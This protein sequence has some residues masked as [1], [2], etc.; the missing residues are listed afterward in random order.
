MSLLDEYF[1]D[2]PYCG[3]NISILIDTSVDYQDYYE[4]CSVCCAP[5]FFLISCNGES[6]DVVIKSDNE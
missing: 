2:C 6:V 4:D 5:I 3:E 1:I